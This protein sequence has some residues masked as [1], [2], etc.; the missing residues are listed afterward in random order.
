MRKGVPL[1]LWALRHLRRSP[2]APAVRVLTG[3]RL[4]EHPCARTVCTQQSRSSQTYRVSQLH[5]FHPL[6]QRGGMDGYRQ[7]KLRR[8]CWRRCVA[9]FSEMTAHIWT[10]RQASWA[11]RSARSERSTPPEC[12]L[13]F[14]CS[15]AYEDDHQAGGNRVFCTLGRHQ[16]LIRGVAVRTGGEGDA[17]E[18]V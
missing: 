7:G 15:N 1:V 2:A 16:L 8:E 6:G 4:V 10:R 3:P 5:H 11:L 12:S 14:P 9:A 17:A 18:H 13:A